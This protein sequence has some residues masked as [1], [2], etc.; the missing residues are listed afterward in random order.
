MH[1]QAWI[2]S[3]GRDLRYIRAA[4]EWTFSRE[5]KVETG[6]DLLSRTAHLWYF[7]GSLD[8]LDA[9]IAKASE[10]MGAATPAIVGTLMLH[11]CYRADGSAALALARQAIDAFAEAGDQ[12][13]LIFA[14]VAAARNA[15]LSQ[16]LDEAETYLHK[17]RA[18]LHPASSLRAQER[19]L[20]VCVLVDWARRGFPSVRESCKDLAQIADRL[21]SWRSRLIRPWHFGSPLRVR[22]GDRGDRNSRHSS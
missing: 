9:W 14:N 11:R 15:Y 10:H 4:L 12:D 3:Y 17:A 19:Y 6:L 16:E 13:G 20:Q 21:G 18:T 8:E 1:E 22:R 2:E 7:Y 5:G